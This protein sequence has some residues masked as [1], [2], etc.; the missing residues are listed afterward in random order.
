MKLGVGDIGWSIY[1]NSLRANV[2]A[3]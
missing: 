1:Y 2:V 3:G